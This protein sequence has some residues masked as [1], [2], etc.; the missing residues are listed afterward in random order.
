MYGRLYHALLL[1]FCKRSEAVAPL[2]VVAFFQQSRYQRQRF[3]A[4]AY[5][6]YVSL[7]ALVYLRT[8]DVEVYH[9]GLFGEC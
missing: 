3:L 8:V 6:G 7:Y 4:V 9:L 1:L 2:P 5:D